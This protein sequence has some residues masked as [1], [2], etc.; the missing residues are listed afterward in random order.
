MTVAAPGFTGA[1][2]DR[3]DAIRTDPAKL[4]TLRA[5][6]RSRVLRLAGLDPQAFEGEL[7]W[8]ALGTADAVLFLGLIDGV[9]HFAALPAAGQTIDGRSRSCWATL[10]AL[11]PDQAALYAGARSLIAWHATHRFCPNCAAETV[12]Q[13][14][15][16]ARKC[17]RCH[18]EHFPRT[19]PVA[20][21]L[22]EHGDRVLLGHHVGFPQG[23]YSALAGFVEPGESIEEAV[24]RE[25]FEEAG[26][27]ATGVRYVAS[28]PWPFPSSLMI[29][30]VATVE[31]DAL[32][33]QASEI[34]D[35]IWVSR[36]EVRASL[37]NA[38]DARFPPPPPI[39]IARTLLETWLDARPGRGATVP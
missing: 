10:Q 21:M 24:A 7:V 4:E 23:R 32:T 26:V 39:A 13:K 29:G 16:W 5:D 27:R 14:G 35:A 36:D 33:L 25:L 6:A 3:A 8:D 30:C 12:V 18:T 22:A 2:I 1:L 38:S 31:S 37:A 17:L 19:D 11:R 9:G 34:D 20:I 28:Q 15:G